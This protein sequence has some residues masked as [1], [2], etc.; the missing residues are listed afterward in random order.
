MT[1]DRPRVIAFLS[2]KGG[3]GKTTVAIAMG[4]LLADMGHRCLLVDFDLATNGASYFFTK[5]FGPWSTGFWELL[6][7]LRTGEEPL[8]DDARRSI[9]QVAPN[10]YFFASRVGLSRKGEPYEAIRIDSGMLRERVLKPLLVWAANIGGIE[11]V[12]IDSQAGYVVPAQAAAEAADTAIIVT[13]ADAISSDAADNLLIQLGSSLPAE[14]RYLV[15]KID[16]RDAET[17]RTMRDVFQT[18]NRLPPLPFDFSVRNAFGARQIPV[19]L[20]RPSPF[21][22]ALFETLKYAFTERFEEI[23]AYQSVHVDSLFKDYQERMEKLVE[24]KHQLEQDRIDLTT[25]RLVRRYR[26]A[27]VALTMAAAWGAALA[28]LPLV[29]Q[30]LGLHTVIDSYL[31]MML[32]VLVVGVSAIGMQF[33]QE[34]RRETVGAR[35]KQ[36]RQAAISERVDSINRELDQLR[37]LLWATSSEYLVDAEVAGATE[38]RRRP[39]PKGSTKA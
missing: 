34:L 25:S 8:L 1:S 11:Y 21:L 15:N 23:A 6:S 20:D 3:T 9:T 35:K 29:A 16:V 10:F 14:R 17:Y 26:L 24:E 12:L 28:A 33:L 36:A 38:M 4:Q 22:F 5:H 39:G 19:S 31:P 32:A 30:W 27:Q 13:E 7:L 18:L 37:S 2:G